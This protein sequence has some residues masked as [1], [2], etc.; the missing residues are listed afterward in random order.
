MS[1]FLCKYF[2]GWHLARLHKDWE[3]LRDNSSPSSFFP[4]SFYFSRLNVLLRLNLDKVQLTTSVIYVHLLSLK[5]SPPRVHRGWAP[6][7]G[8]DFP[9]TDL[10]TRVRDSTDNKMNDLLWLIALHA[11]K[12]CDSLPNWGY[13]S[14]GRSGDCPRKETIDHCFVNCAPSKCVWSHFRPMLTSLMGYALPVK[15]LFSFFDFNNLV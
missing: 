7:L 11:I 5:S 8:P 3:S 15:Q 6:F 9:V 13:I 14:K 2:I 1:F 10:W 12:V 4:T